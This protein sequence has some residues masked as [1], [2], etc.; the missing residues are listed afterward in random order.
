MGTGSS[1]P[2]PPDDPDRTSP[3]SSC[4]SRRFSSEIEVGIGVGAGRRQRRGQ[5]KGHRW[6][7]LG[8]GWGGVGWSGDGAGWAPVGMGFGVGQGRR[9]A[10]ASVV[11]ASV[12]RRL[13]SR[14]AATAHR[15]GR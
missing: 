7:G 4:Q 5:H 2:P 13:P 12:V 15:L 6:V 14:R 8:Q 9:V 11:S 10:A 3:R 1:T